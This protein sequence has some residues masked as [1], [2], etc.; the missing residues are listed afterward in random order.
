MLSNTN[1]QYN[2]AIGH[3]A[4]RRNTSANDNTA[5][6][7]NSLAY[8]TTGLRN[9]A[10]GYFSSLNNTT[11]AYNSAFGDSA[12]Y[13]NTTGSNNIAIGHNADVGL[14]GLSNSIAIGYNAKVYVSNAMVIGNN[15]L[16]TVTTG[17]LLVAA[18][19]NTSSDVR[20]KTNIAPLSS[21]LEKVMQLKPVSY[22]KKLNLASNDYSIQENGFVA[23][24]LRKVLPSLVKEGNDPD[25]I[26]SV[27]YT[28]LIPI[29][30]QAIQEQQKQ[31]DELK[32][33]VNQLLHK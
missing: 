18:G 31:I 17:A 23:Q 6:G 11:G 5:V 3:Q 15:N 24:E 21:S 29:L 16:A 7:N 26:L 10:V 4:L 2:V 27:N 22:A 12:L 1:G 8:T 25:K 30:T 14:S 9:T 33:M 13:T 19:L 32:T 20:L 28:S